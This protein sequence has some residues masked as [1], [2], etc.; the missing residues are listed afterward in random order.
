MLKNEKN[1]KSSMEQQFH[2][3]DVIAFLCVQIWS[4]IP[5]ASE[6]YSRSTVRQNSDGFKFFKNSIWIVSLG[7]SQNLMKI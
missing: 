6:S 1:S 5:S 2:K 7:F 4:Y 3:S